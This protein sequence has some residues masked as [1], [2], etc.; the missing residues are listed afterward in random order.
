[1]IVFIRQILYIVFIRR[2]LYGPALAFQPHPL[3]SPERSNGKHHINLDANP[4]NNDLRFHD[5]AVHEDYLD[6]PRRVN[7][8]ANLPCR[9]AISGVHSAATGNWR[10]ASAV[11][12]YILERGM[13]GQL[14]M[15]AAKTY[16][17][18]VKPGTMLRARLS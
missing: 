14:A 4:N 6:R 7:G 12:P 13:G 18:G 17:A 5:R 2:I 10:Y 8:A 16:A 15:Y 3:S 11:P 9:Q 1:M